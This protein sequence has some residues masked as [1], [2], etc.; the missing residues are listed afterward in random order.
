MK[1]LVVMDV[2]GVLFKGQFIFHLAWR[3]GIW[4]YIRTALLCLLFNMNKLSIQE[5][6]TRVYAR[7]RGVT[8]AHSL[9]VYRDIPII[10]HAKET[11]AIL[12]NH[13]YHVA[14]IS[15]GVPDDFVRDLAVRLSADAGYGIEVGIDN[16][17]LTGNVSGSLSSPSGKKALVEKIL[18]GHGLDWKD[19]V[20]LVDDRNNLSIM[21]KASIT[22]GVNAHYSVRQQAQHLVDSG[23]LSEV[24]DIMDVEDADTYT[25]LFAGMRKQFT[26]SWFQEI[27]RKLLHVLVASVPFFAVYAYGVTLSTLG[28]LLCVYMISECLRV[29]GYSFPLIGGITRSSIRMAEARGIA[30]GP[31]TLVLGASVALAFFPAAVSSAVILM[32]AFAD[33]AATIVGRKY[34]AHRIPYNSKK[35]IE[36]SLAA[37]VVAFLCGYFYLPWI[38][39]LAAAVFASGIE[40][41]PL[42]AL[43]NVCMPLGAGIL[44][45][46]IGYA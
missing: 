3:L 41:L 37:C 15:S 24:I 9:A 13:G 22:I 38:P 34:G 35:S 18:Q 42:K 11:I 16:G 31:V 43:D 1:K 17:R 39:A 6:L 23:D 45:V 46:C 27:R 21:H 4:V 7:F 12:R 25:T 2:D 5:L 20:I 30:F 29:N 19:T 26:H 33:T 14:L 8:L 28:V 32:V 40:S 10:R 36:G 44:L